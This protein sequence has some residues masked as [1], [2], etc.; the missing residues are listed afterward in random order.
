MPHLL[1][2]LLLPCLLAT[3]LPAHAALPESEVRAAIIVNFIHYVEWPDSPPPTAETLICVV[4]R[5]ATADALLTFNGKSVRGR[6]VAVVSRQYAASSGDC[7]VLFL[8]DSSTRSAADWLRDL[9][10]QPVLTISEGEDFLPNGGIVAINR[11]GSR[12]VFDVNLAAMRRA[13][14]RISSQLLRLA[15]E[16]HGK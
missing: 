1:R 16:V 13:N 12:V 4:G 9:A 10:G 3:T 8:G 2:R 6:P 11:S 5:N 7:R 14:L 15:R